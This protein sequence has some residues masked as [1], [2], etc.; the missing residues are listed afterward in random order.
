[1]KTPTWPFIKVESTYEY[2]AIRDFYG[3]DCAKRSGVQLMQ[4]I[5]EGLAILKSIGASMAAQCAY[6]LH[7]L[8]Q[9]D[10]VYAQHYDRLKVDSKISLVSLERAV[11]Y[12]H[13]ANMYLCK[14]E[15]DSWTLATMA[16]KIGFIP[17]DVH[18]MLIADKRQN[19]KD[20]MRHHFGTHERSLELTR[21]FNNWLEYL[22][23]LGA[24]TDN[25]KN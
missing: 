12:R 8:V 13:Y 5:D 22:G 11:E 1:M 21:Y 6:C 18:H 2:R 24:P 9:G 3:T 10:D 20:F 23:V 15:T 19:F 14:P 17:T 16:E 4:H 7:P 25:E